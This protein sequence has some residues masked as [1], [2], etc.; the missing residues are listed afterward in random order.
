[1]ELIVV[2]VPSA[3]S[4]AASQPPVQSIAHLPV[5]STSSAFK[6]WLLRGCS[7]KII[8][9]QF[10]AVSGT[11]YQG[12]SHKQTDD[13]IYTRSRLLN[14]RRYCKIGSLSFPVKDMSKAS[15]NNII[16]GGFKKYFAC[17]CIPSYS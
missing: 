10:E 15:F 3:S 9:Y 12:I 13:S 2:P 11:V 6:N 17:L 4:Q 5:T 14:C 1:M 8:R 16:L 7:K